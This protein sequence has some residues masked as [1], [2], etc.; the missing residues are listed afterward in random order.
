M[1]DINSD[2]RDDRPLIREDGVED[3][4]SDIEIEAR[5]CMSSPLCHPAHSLHRYFVLVFMCFLGFGRSPFY[6]NI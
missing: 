2:G 4:T 6:Y 3:Q 1:S 5:G